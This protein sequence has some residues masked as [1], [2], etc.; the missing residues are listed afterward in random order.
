V[1]TFVA[2]LKVVLPQLSLLNSSLSL[3]VYAY[4]QDDNI[5]VYMSFSS[6]PLLAG[7]RVRTSVV[8]SLVAACVIT[9]RMASRRR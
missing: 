8:F 7:F 9:F 1:R 2:Y 6:E 5:S 3:N 4:S